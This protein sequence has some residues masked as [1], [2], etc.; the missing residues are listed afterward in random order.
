MGKR[1]IAVLLLIVFCLSAC[2][3]GQQLVFDDLQLTLPETYINLSSEDYA[4]D[5]DFL[6][7]NEG[8]ILLGFAENRADL[9]DC[10]LAAYTELL[11][12]GNDLGCIPEQTNFGYRFSYEAP[13]E[14]EYYIYEVGIYASQDRFW[15]IQCY[16]LAEDHPRYTE[17]IARIFDSI[18]ILS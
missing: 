15:T 2:Q 14:D 7:G 16:C 5:A 9:N 13:V 6:Y 4:A 10:T 11:I 8:L 12:L 3:K 18:Q 17:E 1:T